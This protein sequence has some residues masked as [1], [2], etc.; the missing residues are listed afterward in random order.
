MPEVTLQ[1]LYIWQMVIEIF[2]YKK[3]NVISGKRRLEI[4]S[5]GLGSIISMDFYFGGVGWYSWNYSTGAI[6]V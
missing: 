3:Y 6:F 5:H 1:T 4:R 2:N